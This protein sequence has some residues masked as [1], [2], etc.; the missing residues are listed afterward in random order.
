MQARYTLGPDRM[1]EMINGMIRGGGRGGGGGAAGAAGGAGG[2]GAAGG[3]NFPGAALLNLNPANAI[4]QL[5]D[6]LQLTEVQVAAIKPLA[7]SV[8]ARNAELGREVQETIR[9]AGANPDMGAVMA[10]V[11]TR[12]ESFRGET[13]A[14]IKRLQGILTAEQWARVPE[15]IKNP[16]RLGG[17]QRRRG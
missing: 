14:V 10:R 8:A 4:L 2:G 15:R 6:S 16:P 7:D 17:Q 3:A 13:E 11:N 9:A 5:K 12:L 1:R